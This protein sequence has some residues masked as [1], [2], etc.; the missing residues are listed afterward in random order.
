MG[1]RKL[2]YNLQDHI[3]YCCNPE[4][5]FMVQ[6]KFFLFMHES[7]S[8]NY[9]DATKYLMGFNIKG[10]I[11]RVSSFAYNK[12]DECVSFEKSDFLSG[13]MNPFHLLSRRLRTFCVPNDKSVLYINQFLQCT[14]NG[15]F[16]ITGKEL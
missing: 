9:D 11:E 8:C 16:S 10:A 7:H 2:F 13:N 4:F 1:S 3:F 14:D 15:I 12:K 6:S 5:W